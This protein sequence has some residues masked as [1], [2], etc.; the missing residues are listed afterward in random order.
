MGLT[1]W[2]HCPVTREGPVVEAK[3]VL[4]ASLLESCLLL[5]R[6]CVPF[7]WLGFVLGRDHSLQ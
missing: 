2:L 1:R 4:Q 3:V 7:P 6:I 5:V